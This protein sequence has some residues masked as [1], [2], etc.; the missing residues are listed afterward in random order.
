MGSNPTL[1]AILTFLV[2][3]LSRCARPT[4]STPPAPSSFICARIRAFFQLDLPV[5]GKHRVGKDKFPEGAHGM[6]ADR[7][8]TTLEIETSTC[9]TESYRRAS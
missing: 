9:E 4:P 6:M 3:G 7:T 8:R 5:L 1:S 2:N